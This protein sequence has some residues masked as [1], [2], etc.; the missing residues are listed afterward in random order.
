MIYSNS[1]DLSTK[2]RFNLYL[3]SLLIDEYNAQFKT[4]FTEDQFSLKRIE[5]SGYS[6]LAFEAISNGFG[7]D[8]K[9]KIRAYLSLGNVTNMGP[10]APAVTADYVIGDLGDEAVVTHGSIDYE[11]IRNAGF[12][13]KA[14][15]AQHD[16]IDIILLET[17]SYVQ[18]EDDGFLATEEAP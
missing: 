4:K 17:G 14:W 10:F 7:L 1:A 15:L 6:Q 12:N 16:Q 2:E 3:K 5:N 18:L 9:F 8:R 11:G 13:V